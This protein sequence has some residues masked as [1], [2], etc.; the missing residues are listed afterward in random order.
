MDILG[1]IGGDEAADEGAVAKIVRR[2]AGA[3]GEKVEAAGDAVAEEVR[4]AVQ[5]RVDDR[6]GDG[7]VP[8]L[9]GEIGQAAALVLPAGGGAA[10]EGGVRRGVG[11]GGDAPA[12]QCVQRG[13]GIRHSGV[14][15]HPGAAPQVQ[16]ILGMGVGQEAVILDQ[17]PPALAGLGNGDL[18]GIGV[19]V[20]LAG[21]TFADS[22]DGEEGAVL[23]IHGRSVQQDLTAVH[24][25]DRLAA[26]ELHTGAVAAGDGDHAVLIG[27]VAPQGLHQ[28][29]GREKG[30]GVDGLGGDPRLVGIDG[31]RLAVHHHVGAA[32]SKLDGAHIIIAP[33]AEAGEFDIVVPGGSREYGPGG[34]KQA[35][36]QGQHQDSG[37]QA[38]HSGLLSDGWTDGGPCPGPWGPRARMTDVT[39]PGFPAGEAG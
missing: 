9:A 13:G 36:E 22:P 24:P 37:T 33:G 5:P 31:A 1:G 16:D 28:G 3:A 30:A 39:L 10:L 6:H 18:L 17:E 23:G 38:F 20:H 21:E 12:L 19:P 2:D 26:G 7:T 14:D 29:P 15:Q 27:D 35:G 11:P 32:Q 25:H 4:T 34:G 8:A